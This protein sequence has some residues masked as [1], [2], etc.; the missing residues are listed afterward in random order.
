M[1]EKFARFM[2]WFDMVWILWDVSTHRTA[3]FLVVIN[4]ILIQPDY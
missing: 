3:L 1:R 2:G 4:Y